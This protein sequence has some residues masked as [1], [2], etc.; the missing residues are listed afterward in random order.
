MIKLILQVLLFY[1]FKCKV[2][3]RI[4]L[5]DLL[6]ANK[7]SLDIDDPPVICQTSLTTTAASQSEEFVDIVTRREV[8]G[9]YFV[10]QYLS[11][12]SNTY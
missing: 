1:H 11:S 10:L 6:P 2:S 5:F 8:E 7:L 9:V 3:I 4:F 12:D